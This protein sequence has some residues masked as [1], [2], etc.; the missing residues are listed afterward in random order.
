MRENVL[1]FDPLVRA[2]VNP[3]RVSSPRGPNEYVF[4]MYLQQITLQVSHIKLQQFINCGH[5]T[6]CFL[7]S[8]YCN[9]QLY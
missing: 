7:W 5:Q 8:P 2:T 3:S 1:C 4:Y 6:E 9:F